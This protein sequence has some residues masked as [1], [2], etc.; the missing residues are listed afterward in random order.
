LRRREA[1]GGGARVSVPLRR[2]VLDRL[3]VRVP[4]DRLLALLCL[5]ALL[6]LLLR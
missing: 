6:A 4:G 5:L 2:R 1:S 3:R